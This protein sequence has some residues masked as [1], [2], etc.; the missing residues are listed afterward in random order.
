MGGDVDHRNEW[1][2]PRPGR[3]ALDISCER[4]TYEDISTRDTRALL[5]GGGM[6]M[7]S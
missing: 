3:T 6:I 7:M 1:S 2:N 5:G 4:A